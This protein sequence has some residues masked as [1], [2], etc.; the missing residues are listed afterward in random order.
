MKTKEIVLIIIFVLGLFNDCFTQTDINKDLIY[1]GLEQTP[2]LEF[3]KI[4]KDLDYSEGVKELKLPSFWDL[5]LEGNF[6]PHLDQKMTSACTIFALSYAL[7]TFQ[8]AEDYGHS[9]YDAKGK[10]IDSLVFSPSYLFKVFKQGKN[11]SSGINLNEA[12]LY[13]ENYGTVSIDDLPFDEN[14]ILNDCKQPEEGLIDK[15]RINRIAN[16]YVLSKDNRERYNPEELSI[17]TRIKKRL[18]NKHPVVFSAEY[19][20]QFKRED[21]SKFHPKDKY[22]I[23][24]SKKSKRFEK[25]HAMLIIGY[26]DSIGAFKV[27]NSWGKYGYIWMTYELF[28]K[29][30]TYE[31][32]ATIDVPH[33]YHNN[34]LNIYASEEQNF[35]WKRNK[36]SFGEDKI[37]LAA[38]I[39]EHSYISNEMFEFANLKT[40]DK[41][42]SV[43][44]G[45]RDK[46]IR[47]EMFKFV[48]NVGD[49]VQIG[50]GKKQYTFLVDSIRNQKKIAFFKILIEGDSIYYSNEQFRNFPIKS[51]NLKADRL[52]GKSYRFRDI[53]VSLESNGIFKATARQTNNRW[54]GWHGKIVFRLFDKQKRLIKVIDTPSYG[55]NGVWESGGKENE[56]IINFETL[57]TDINIV[58]RVNHITIEPRRD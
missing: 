55:Q 22:P 13:L 38:G 35:D 27:Y 44:I 21:Y 10:V 7:K 34:Y 46:S 17:I 20:E 3:I 51:Q 15:G 29:L 19:N 28:K 14:E 5:S 18:I 40:D 54:A 56:R 43:H 31:I 52:R 16:F 25:Y 4:P 50:I 30:S 36:N 48:Q 6:P 42:Q 2:P 37:G 26:D 1:T 45:V 12:L 47:G 23:W 11:C 33:K 24:D 41:S 9:I 32:Y 57:I 8:E 53:Y 58:K 49:T 39:K